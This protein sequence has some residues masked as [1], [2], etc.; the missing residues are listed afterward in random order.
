MPRTIPPPY[1]GKASIRQAFPRTCCEGGKDSQPSLP[2]GK[3]CLHPPRQQ[4]GNPS[5]FRTASR[6]LN[7]KPLPNSPSNLP[8]LHWHLYDSLVVQATSCL[9]V[10]NTCFLLVPIP[11]DCPLICSPSSQRDPLKS[12]LILSPS[13]SN[14]SG[15]FQ[16]CWD[17]APTAQPAR[18]GSTQPGAGEG[19]HPWAPML[20]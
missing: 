14:C 20:P 19:G 9:D 12:N 13:C 3:G 10:C 5:I 6:C 2:P 17:L 16:C 15:I 8:R 7:I 18:Q 4:A 1:Q 11:P